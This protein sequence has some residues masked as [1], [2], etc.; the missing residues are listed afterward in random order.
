MTANDGLW[1]RSIA[2]T[3]EMVEMA[4]MVEM[5]GMVEEKRESAAVCRAAK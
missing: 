5:L 4:E 1:R 3:L 2:E